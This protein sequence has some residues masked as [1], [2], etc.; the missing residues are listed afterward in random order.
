[1]T[2]SIIALTANTSNLTCIANDYGYDH[3]FSRQAQALVQQNDSLIVYSTSGKS[4]NII[5]LVKE[6]R[7]K[8]RHIIA[9]TGTY[10]DDLAQYSD[11]VISVNSNK[12][13]RIQEIHAIA[14]HIMCE[15]VEE[16]LFKQTKN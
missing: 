14:G 10:K 5:K 13:T 16:T 9:L 15:C 4:S 2:K 11:V 12:T 6:T 1:M 8:V 3:I 7:D